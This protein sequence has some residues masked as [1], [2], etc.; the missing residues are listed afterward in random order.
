MRYH[1]VVTKPN[2]DGSTTETHFATDLS[3]R[4]AVLILVAL[5]VFLILVFRCDC[6]STTESA[7][8]SAQVSGYY[9]DQSLKTDEIQA[10]KNKAANL[11]RAISM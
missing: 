7:E 8:I 6:Q 11:F 9:L 1:R 5:I 4:K 3:L 10:L 2:E